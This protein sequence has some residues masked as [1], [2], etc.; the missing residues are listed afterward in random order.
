MIG[1]II[2]T[3]FG[4][5]NCK[6]AL[7]IE[8]PWKTNKNLHHPNLRLNNHGHHGDQ[9]PNSDKICEQLEYPWT[10]YNAYNQYVRL[11]EELSNKI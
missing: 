4:Y 1:N 10:S 5:A 8:I 11:I 7:R 3:K 9:Q 6:S 2:E